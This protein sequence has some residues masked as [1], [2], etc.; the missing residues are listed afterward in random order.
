MAE[1]SVPKLSR[2][3]NWLADPSRLYPCAK[4]DTLSGCARAISFHPIARR[5]MA[6]PQYRHLT[7]R[8][9]QN[10]L[11]MT[12]TDTQLQDEALA[13]ELLQ[14][15]LDAVRQFAAQKAVVD[16]QRIKYMSSVAFRPLLRLR[17]KLQ[18]TGG[19]MILCGLTRVVGD[20]FYTTKMLSP[21]GSF[22]APF[23]ME[24]DVAAAVDRLNREAAN[25]PP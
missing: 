11:V 16:M 20:I 18:E 2:A 21:T 22:D 25:P 8:V 12:L 5:A 10:V 17:A 23:Q 6:E 7:T 3:N 4:R 1:S 24:P 14:E 19:R 15:F 13:T 9:D